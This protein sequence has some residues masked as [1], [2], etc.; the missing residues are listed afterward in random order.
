MEK[1]IIQAIKDAEG[2]RPFAKAGDKDVVTFEQYNDLAVLDDQLNAV[3]GM[4]T[5]DSRG[6]P[7]SSV[8]TRVAYNPDVYFDNRYR[9]VKD[10]IQVITDHRALTEQQTGR[11][12]ASQIPAAVL[13]R[14]DGKLV[15]ERTALVSDKEFL[16][17]FKQK[18]S[19]KA[20]AE[21]MSA[22]AE[23]AVTPMTADELP[24]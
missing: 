15:Y 4:P 13:V 6:L 10:A 20:M 9:K 3:P 7:T 12:Y 11:I 21:V 19:N 1:T 22:L 14:K 23:Q 24:I 17:S 2:V 5:L 18:L 8:T 16:D